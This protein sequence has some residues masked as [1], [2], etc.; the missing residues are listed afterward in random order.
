MK[1][2]FK[3]QTYRLCFIFYL[4]YMFLSPIITLILIFRSISIIQL[5]IIK[6]VLFGLLYIQFISNVKLN[7]KLTFYQNFGLSRI[8]IFSFLYLLDSLF[9][10][11]TFKAISLF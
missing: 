6:T 11:L 8:K 3:L 7:Q 9:T 1:S 10:L 5:F 4:T 2:F